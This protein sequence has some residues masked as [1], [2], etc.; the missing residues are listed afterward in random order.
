MIVSNRSLYIAGIT[1]F[2]GASFWLSSLVF[3]KAQAQS[4]SIPFVARLS[5]RYFKWDT[6]TNP[7]VVHTVHARRRDRSFVTQIASS[8]GPHG[9]GE[10]LIQI[11]DA[12]SHHDIVL[13][14]LT[15]SKVTYM[16]SQQQ[17]DNFIS[18][19]EAESC[20]ANVESGTGTFKGQA[21]SF[22][23]A[24]FYETK[25]IRLNPSANLNVE[26]W[27]IAA[28]RCFTSKRIAKLG[29]GARNE[30]VTDSLQEGDPPTTL[31][32]IP[33]DYVERSPAEVEAIFKAKVQP[34]GFYGDSASKGLDNFYSRLKRENGSR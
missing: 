8:N 28:L 30:L 23:R 3:A 17:F 27:T 12:E 20:P 32:D 34:A 7:T 14:P 21:L 2:G 25:N 15:K 4:D 18:G 26:K 33:P 31:F 19:L 13:E 10:P 22:G 6:D 1:A 16:Y 11:V 29:D 24:T 5:E 9:E